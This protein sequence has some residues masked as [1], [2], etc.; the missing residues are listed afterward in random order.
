MRVR[1]QIV[2]TL[3]LVLAAAAT[4]TLTVL[5]T[6]Q[7]IDQVA[8]LQTVSDGSTILATYEGSSIQLRRVDSRG[9]VRSGAAL[10]RKR[11][12]KIVSL[13]DMGADEEGSVYLLKNL[14]NPRS[15][16]L[17]AQELEIYHLDQLWGK[18]QARVSLPL[19]GTFRYRWLSVGSSAVLMGTDRNE[20]QLTRYAYDPSSLYF[21]TLPEAKSIRTYPLAAGEGIHQAVIAG[22]DLAYL[23][24][25]GKV[26]AVS[27]AEE[28]PVEVYPARELTQVLYAC[29]LSP[30]SRESVYLL[31]QESGDILTL[32]LGSGET[33]I[34]KNGT[35]PFSGMS[36]YAP[37]DIRGLSMVDAANFSALVRSQ[38]GDGFELLSSYAGSA[39]VASGLER[40]NSAALLRALAIWLSLSIA[41]TLIWMVV[42][43]ILH[44][45]ERGRTILIK[46]VTAT[47]P[48]I[49]AALA[50][51]GWFSYTNYATSI[52]QTFQKQVEDEGNM[53]TALFGTESFDEI[54][55]PYDYN[56]DAYAYLSA[57]MGT[58]E[59]YTSVAYYEREQLYIG[60]DE[61]LPCF[62]PFGIRLDTRAEELYLQAAYTGKPQSGM[63][64]DGAGRRIACVTPIGGVSGES[65]YLLETGVLEANLTAY[66][67]AYLRNFLLISLL[68]VAGVALLL[69]ALF[70]RI[71]APIGQIKKGMESFAAGTRNVRLENT[72][73]D[74]FSDIIQVFNN[75]ADDINAKLFR[76]SQTRDT[77]Y[78]FIP[79]K[80]LQ[81]LGKDHLDE[82]LLGV[83]VEQECHVLCASLSLSTRDLDFDQVQE[84]TNRFFN[85]L[86]QSA[87]Q[88]GGILVTDSINLYNLRIIC[89]K[90]GNSAVDIAVSALAAI[91]S[92]NVS[93]PLQHQLE[94]MTVLHKTRMYYGICGNETRLVPTLFAEELDYLVK[95]E[96]RLR[97]FA[98]RLL[99]TEAAFADVD[100]DR[101][102]HRFIGYPDIGAA[103]QLGLYDFYDADTA[104]QIRLINDTR[105]TFDKAMQLLA[106]QRWYDAK[107]IFALVLR[108]NQQDHVAKHYVFVCEKNL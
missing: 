4:V 19:D 34:I 99:V 17:E 106:D 23:S 108:Q 22:T 45:M 26:F 62:Y 11:D 77:Y 31:A 20:T 49:I 66:T 105:V 13:V 21:K 61:N 10:A 30:Q 18:R 104:E 14:L 87:E 90:G 71:L 83:G 1:N 9:V 97:R 51:F 24:K 76:L 40:S 53:L 86:H 74:E 52:Q 32:S 55:Y 82:V 65:V 54:E 16:A 85:I 67:D 43:R 28:E 57:M 107:N 8:G 78:R 101:Y 89:P 84:L 60:V 25:S 2:V 63:L 100:A 94:V 96:D 38:T 68:F 44:L 95:N 6:E 42:R 91:D 72:A 39:S 56:N 7:V 81:L 36:S 27:E 73:S 3:L 12:G 5:D 80:M 50:L 58:R 88:H 69:I 47:I 35:E 103:R 37:V 92:V 70:T 98:C 48:M 102:Y 29:F 46:L 41:L 79:Q 59:A 64:D 93:L 15:G 33:Q 75:M